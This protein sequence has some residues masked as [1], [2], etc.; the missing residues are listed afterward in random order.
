MGSLFIKPQF[1][2]RHVAMTL[3][4]LVMLLLPLHVIAQ[5]WFGD[6]DLD[7][8]V[9]ITDVTSLIDHLLAN[10]PFTPFNPYE[11]RLTAKG[12]GAVGDGVTDDTDAIQKAINYIRTISRNILL[13]SQPTVDDLPKFANEKAIGS[14][15]DNIVAPELFF[16]KGRYIVSRTLVG[17]S[18]FLRG[19]NGS[20]IV[21][22]DSEK[23]VLYLNWGYRLRISSLAFDGGRRQV[24]LYTANN[25]IAN[26]CIENCTFRNSTGYAIWSR[27]FRRPGGKD[28]RTITMGPYE[29]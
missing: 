20:V 11:T 28:F 16:P 8:K 19:E 1:S 6:V 29:V 23:D 4:T 24:L 10:D 3:A 27:N 12:Y 14:N 17:G 25:D 5:D 9:S 2:L 15:S 26:L 21:M 13:A 22:K 7:G 18:L